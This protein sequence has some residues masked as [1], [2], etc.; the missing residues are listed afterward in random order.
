MTFASLACEIEATAACLSQPATDSH[1]RFLEARYDWLVTMLEAGPEV[2]GPWSD[3]E[4]WLAKQAA[5]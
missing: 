1:R 4:D 5:A 2:A 3:I